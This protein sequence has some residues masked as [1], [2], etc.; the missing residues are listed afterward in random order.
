M[1]NEKLTAYI[2]RKTPVDFW[3]LVTLWP[4]V[5]LLCL[6]THSGEEV[7]L[8]HLGFVHLSI[9]SLCLF[10]TPLLKKIWFMASYNK[11]HATFIK[12]WTLF[13]TTLRWTITELPKTITL[14]TAGTLIISSSIC[15]YSPVSSSTTHGDTVVSALL[16]LHR[17]TVLLSGGTKRKAPP[18]CW[19]GAFSMALCQGRL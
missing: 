9:L 16:P 1:G 8:T 4:F 2:R 14:I 5:S 13:V 3:N 6:W 17:L 7:V 12:L 15:V 18:C 19:A 11:T 10:F